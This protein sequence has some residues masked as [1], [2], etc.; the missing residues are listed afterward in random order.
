MATTL[1]ADFGLP[2]ELV[3]LID[4]GTLQILEADE[5]KKTIEFHLPHLRR[6]DLNGRITTVSVT[7]IHPAFNAEFCHYYEQTPGDGPNFYVTVDTDEVG[8]ELLD[9]ESVEQLLEW[10]ADAEQP[11]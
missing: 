3:R 4:S 1:E 9:L 10:I 11:E 7:W 2:P 6:R 8:D 5:A